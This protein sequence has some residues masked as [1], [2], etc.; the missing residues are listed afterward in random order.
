MV[1]GGTVAPFKMPNQS[2]IS[3]YTNR[4]Q[5]V[6]LVLFALRKLGGSNA[7]QAVID[8]IRNGGWYDVTRHDLPP[9]PGQNESR[10][11]TLLAWARKDSY[12]RDWLI[13]TD[14]K[15]DWAI[16]RQGRSI[17][18]KAEERYEKREWN[19]RECY[20][21]KASFKKIVDPAYEPSSADAIRPVP[22]ALPYF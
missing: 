12:E 18:E 3:P 7:K 15:D 8:C 10:Y 21:W 5:C 17:L 22:Q 1:L 19:V 9:Y 11:H 14:E 13:Q 6:F 20:L 2:R 16:S 4:G